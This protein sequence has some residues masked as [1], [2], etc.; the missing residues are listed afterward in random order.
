MVETTA[1]QVMDTVPLVMRIIRAEMRSHRTPDL[2][3]PQFRALLYVS[4]REQVSLSDVADHLGL[5]LPSVSKLVDKLVERG[6]MFRTNAADDR[7]RMILTLTPAGQAA[8]ESAAQ[9]TQARLIEQL[10]TLSPEE[11]A[12][13]SEAMRLLRR[14]LTSDPGAESSER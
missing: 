12:V 14:A 7:R 9:A 10:N 1:A 13:V 8:R 5:T 6:L 2:T 4:R 3:V 11:C